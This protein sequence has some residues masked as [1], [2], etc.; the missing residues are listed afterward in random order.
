MSANRLF[1]PLI[2][3][4][5]CLEVHEREKALQAKFWKTENSW[6]YS[7]RQKAENQFDLH[8]EILK[9]LRNWHQK[10]PLEVVAKQ[11][12]W[13][14]LDWLKVYIL[15]LDSGSPA[16]NSRVTKFAVFV[17]TNLTDLC[18]IL[19]YMHLS[20]FSFLFFY[21]K[22]KGRWEEAILHWGAC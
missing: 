7:L 20:L 22:R 5:K 6:I 11:R 18:D 10:L 14:K 16:Q 8:Q 4:S 19:N 12:S 2:H 9:R 15:E 1:P 13:N 3:K 21:E 17:L